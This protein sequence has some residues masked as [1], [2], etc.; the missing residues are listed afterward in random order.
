[1][2]DLILIL[3]FGFFAFVGILYFVGILFEIIT[4]II[5]WYQRREVK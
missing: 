3:G 4:R 5:D 1:M 2:I